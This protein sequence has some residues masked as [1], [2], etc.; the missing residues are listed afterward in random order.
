MPDNTRPHLREGV[1]RRR[2]DLPE[3]GSKGG[4]LGRGGGAALVPLRK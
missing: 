2:R 1:A 4:V 3:V